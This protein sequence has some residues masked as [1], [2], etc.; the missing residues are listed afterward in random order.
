SLD[1]PPGEMVALLGR[2]GAGKSTLLNL[3]TGG[4][5]PT[6]GRLLLDG[7]DL[8]RIPPRVRARSVALVPQTL[9]LP[10]AF[11]VREW[12]SLGR[13]PYLAPLRGESAEDREAIF[14]AMEQ[15]EVLDLEE[16]RVGEISG[17]ERQRAA[18][19]QA[20]AQEPALLLLDEATAHLD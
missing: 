15:A 9:S 11:T 3:V 7:A 20:L 4:L 14:W 17:G 18:L 12:I 10:F 6:S 16:R 13:T 8:L 1:V 2:N 19:A 5:R